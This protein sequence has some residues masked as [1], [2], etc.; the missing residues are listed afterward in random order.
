MR[1][2]DSSPSDVI[3]EGNVDVLTPL[4][5]SPSP[6]CWRRSTIRQKIKTGHGWGWSAFITK[7]QVE[8]K[9]AEFLQNDAL[10]INFNGSSEYAQYIS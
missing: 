3:V 8:T 6:S 2:K 10:T 1:N 4:S 5:C 7:E 9:K